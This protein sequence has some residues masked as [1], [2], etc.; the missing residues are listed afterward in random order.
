[1]EYQQTEGT[2]QMP[3]EALVLINKFVSCAELS[4]CYRLLATAGK[5]NEAALWIS[6]TGGEEESIVFV[7]ADLGRAIG[8]FERLIAGAVTPCSLEDVV[9]D[10]LWLDSRC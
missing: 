2:A 6:V 3:K 5:K 7:G 10:F 9:Q 4:M 8:Y 1:M